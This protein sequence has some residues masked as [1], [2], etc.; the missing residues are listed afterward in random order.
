MITH[1][2]ALFIFQN[3]PKAGNF[4]IDRLKLELAGM[5]VDDDYAR[6]VPVRY[7]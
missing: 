4:E 1:R 7:I 5:K 6:C 3:C 2:R